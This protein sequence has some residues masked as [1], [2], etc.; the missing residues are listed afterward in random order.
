[1]NLKELTRK[2]GQLSWFTRAE[3][4]VGRWPFRW[5]RKSKA[6]IQL[7]HRKKGGVNS[8][9]VTTMGQTPDTSANPQDHLCYM[10]SQG[11][12]VSDQTRYMTLT[13]APKFHCGHCGRQAASDGSLCLPMEL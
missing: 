12:N 13:T 2:A 7:L 8:N 1:M 3:N 6:L 11:F 9:K 10:I 5:L 4:P